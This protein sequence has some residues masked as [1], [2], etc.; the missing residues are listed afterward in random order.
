MMDGRLLRGGG[1]RRLESLDDVFAREHVS[2]LNGNPG[3]VRRRDYILD[4]AR[5]GDIEELIDLLLGHGHG[6]GAGLPA[7]TGFVPFDAPKLP[8]RL[9]YASTVSIPDNQK[10]ASPTYERRTAPIN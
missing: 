10:P 9:A 7:G 2:I 3:D 8:K 5:A 1:C 6:V 4:V